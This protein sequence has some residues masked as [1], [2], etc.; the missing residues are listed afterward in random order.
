[1]PSPSPC[2]FGP[3]VLCLQVLVMSKVKKIKIDL[4]VVAVVVIQ[5]AC[6]IGDFSSCVGG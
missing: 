1:M 6:E 5:G 3:H 4:I 2:C